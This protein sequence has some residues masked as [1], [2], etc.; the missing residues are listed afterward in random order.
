VVGLRPVAN[1]PVIL[2]TSRHVVQG[3]DIEAEE[4]DATKR[5][6]T[7]RSRRLDARPYTVTVT[8]PRGFV[9]TAARRLPTGHVVLEWP[10]S[11]TVRELDWTLKF[12]RRP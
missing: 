6:L 3:V 9:T 12:S 4:W 7:V 8:V 1:R 5:M 11:D 2:G 10:A